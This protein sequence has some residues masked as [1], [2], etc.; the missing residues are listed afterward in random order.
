MS[1]KQTHQ[2]P[3]CSAFTAQTLRQF[4]HFLDEDLNE[5]IIHFFA[6]INSFHYFIKGKS[7]II[8]L[9]LIE[10]RSARTRIATLASVVIASINQGRSTALKISI[11]DCQIQCVTESSGYKGCNSEWLSEDSHH[12]STERTTKASLPPN[13]NSTGMRREATACL[14]CDHLKDL[15]AHANQSF[16]L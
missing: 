4:L 11:L 12:H 10:T 15:N 13:S 16:S 14:I 9:L 7:T 5:F 3:H 2:I 1:V 8:I 6:H